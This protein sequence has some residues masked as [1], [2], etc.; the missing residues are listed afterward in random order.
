MHSFTQEFIR[1]LD[2]IREGFL[3]I[4]NIE[5]ND[6]DAAY[7]GKTVGPNDK[8]KVLLRWKLDDGRYEVILGDLRSETVTAEKLGELEGK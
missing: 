2:R 6:T 5:I 3:Q 8:D 1:K 4:V 7:D